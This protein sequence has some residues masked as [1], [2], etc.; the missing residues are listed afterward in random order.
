MGAES[1][2]QCSPQEN[3]CVITTKRQVALGSTKVLEGDPQWLRQDGI[4][5]LFHVILDATIPRLIPLILMVGVR[6]S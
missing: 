4:L 5:S 2:K 6:G 1:G 3:Q